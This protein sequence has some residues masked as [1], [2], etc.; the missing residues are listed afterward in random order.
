MRKIELEVPYT[1]KWFPDGNVVEDINTKDICVTG[2]NT[3]TQL[4][5]NGDINAKKIAM[6][7][8]LLHDLRNAE[9]TISH[10][11]IV[12]PPS[13]VSERVLQVLEKIR[14]SILI[15]DTLDK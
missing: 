9:K 10:L 2:A 11:F 1:S 15:M 4:P 7:P 3:M 5:K 12:T 6:L 13:L 8:E 14:T